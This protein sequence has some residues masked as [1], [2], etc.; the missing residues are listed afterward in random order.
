MVVEE[1]QAV[2]L[3]GKGM[4][5]SFLENLP[6]IFPLRVFS[7]HPLLHVFQLITR[8]RPAPSINS[9]P[10][11]VPRIRFLGEGPDKYRGLGCCWKP[12]ES[13]GGLHAVLRFFG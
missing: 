5:L 13:W 12:S 6:K 9:V 8:P 3:Q 2:V 1:R 11:L 4:E 10:R 7:L